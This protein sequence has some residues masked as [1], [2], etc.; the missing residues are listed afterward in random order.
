MNTILSHLWGQYLMVIG[1]VIYKYGTGLGRSISP[2]VGSSSRVMVNLIVV[3]TIFTISNRFNSFK[4]IFGLNKKYLLIW[5]LLGAFSVTFYFQALEQVGVGIST[6][7]LKTNGAF[8]V[9]LSPFWWRTKPPILHYIN[10]GCCILGS[11][12]LVPGPWNV[13]WIGLIS[14]L[15]SGLC[16]AFA[17]LVVGKTMNQEKTL[18]IMFYWSVIGILLHSFIIPMNPVEF[19]FDSTI[20]IF[21]LL[22][23]FLSSFGQYWV[24]GS[25]KSKNNWTIGLISYSSCVLALV[26]DY[27]FLDITFTTTQIWGVLIVITANLSLLIS[28]H[29]KKK[30]KALT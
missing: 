27:I 20:W 25:Y 18:S 7:L 13:G 26:L 10:A 29:A 14:G 19:S 30:N 3:V 16:S 6:F 9:L 1:A 23:A 2:L 21:I 28:I 5:G 8:M 15:L 17:Y 12:L 24:T 11:F 22:S 4:S